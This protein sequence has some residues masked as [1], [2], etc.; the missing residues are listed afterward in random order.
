MTGRLLNLNGI[1][2]FS[3][4]EFKDEFDSGAPLQ[5]VYGTGAALPG[6]EEGMVCVCMCFM[7]KSQHA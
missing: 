3:T 5:W 2:F 7:Y 6:L 4:K 1:M